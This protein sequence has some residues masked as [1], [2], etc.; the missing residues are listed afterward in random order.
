MSEKKTFCANFYA[1]NILFRARHTYTSSHSQ[2]A[3]LDSS[4]TDAARV[5]AYGD[6][7]SRALCNEM[8][9]FF[10]DTR[11]APDVALRAILA[12]VGDS[13][14]T[15]GGSGSVPVRLASVGPHLHKAAYVPI[16]DGAHELRVL[17]DQRDIAGSPFRVDVRAFSTPADLI[18]VDA[19]TLKVGI[20]GDE[21]KTL[22]DARNATP[23]HLSAQCEGPNQLEYCEI[24]DNRDG[25]Y[26]LTV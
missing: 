7:L 5:R 20:L 24:Y 25:T 1:E 17:A 18:S 11:D 12:S 16:N 26:S 4:L 13:K 14:T 22:I 8:A 9:E 19:R 15:S 6:G 21:V 2:S 23:G 10:V 3:S